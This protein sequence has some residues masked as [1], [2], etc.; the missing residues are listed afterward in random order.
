MNRKNVV[1]AV[2]GIATAA[3]LA[4]SLTGCGSSNQSDTSTNSNSTASSELSGSI[5][6]NGSTS[7]EKVIGS[8]SE[9]FMSDN[10]GVTITYDATGSGTGV[11]SAKNGSADIGLASRALKDEETGL[12]TKT[13]ALDGIA[14]VVNSKCGVDD[15]TVEQVAKIFEGKITNWKELGGSDLEISCVG[16]ESGSG[17]RDDFESITETEGKCKLAQELTST[18]AVITAVGSSE[19]AIG[20]ASLSAVEGQDA[21]KALTINGVKCSE[22]TVQ[23]GTYVIQ[24]PFNFVLKDGAELSA[25][26]QA[27]VDFS[28]SEQ[29]DQLIRDAGAVPLA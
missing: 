21:V 11:E 17:T 29:A 13:V 19:N 9:A 12:T 24:R 5:S 25:Q 10:S 7:M 16:R 22:E 28:T 6:T 2:L 27:F 4:F 18:G 14:I 26:A 3:V 23:D 20:Y 15:L 8:L 1:K